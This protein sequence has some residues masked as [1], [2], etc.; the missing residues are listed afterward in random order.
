MTRDELEEGLLLHLSPHK[1]QVA[2]ASFTDLTPFS[3]K[4]EVQG[5]DLLSPKDWP[6]HPGMSCS[7]LPWPLLQD[8]A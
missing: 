6:E 8:S 3:Y 7:S 2:P 4:L 5:L 1:R